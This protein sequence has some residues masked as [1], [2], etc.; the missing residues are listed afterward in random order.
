MSP[1]PYSPLSLFDFHCASLLPYREVV[2]EH[3]DFV[4]NCA[5]FNTFQL[6]NCNTSNIILTELLMV[7]LGKEAGRGGGDTESSKLKYSGWY[8]EKRG[9]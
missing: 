4:R 1:H 7:G 5:N 9:M 3:F 6:T 8:D 2:E